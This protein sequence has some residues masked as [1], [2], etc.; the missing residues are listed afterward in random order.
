MRGSDFVMGMRA[1]K[2]WLYYA[3]FGCNCN[4]FFFFSAFLKVLVLATFSFIPATLTNIQLLVKEGGM[5]SLSKAK[6]NLFS[7]EC[8][9]VFY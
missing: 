7:S 8:V 6:K 3:F 5:F 2:A 4:F 9:G 1:F